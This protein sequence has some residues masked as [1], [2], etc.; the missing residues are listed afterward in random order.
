MSGH[1]DLVHLGRSRWAAIAF[2]EEFGVYAWTG[3]DTELADP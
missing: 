3:Q 2:S 1:H